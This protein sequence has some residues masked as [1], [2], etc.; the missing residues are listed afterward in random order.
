[1]TS[2]KVVTP[3]DPGSSPGGV[4]MICNYL[5]RLGSANA[6]LRARL[7]FIPH[8]MRG[9]NDGESGFLTFY[10]YINFNT[11]KKMRNYLT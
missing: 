11:I 5:K 4:Q 9:L 1:M 2:Q 8:L 10:E 7:E 6:S 3:V